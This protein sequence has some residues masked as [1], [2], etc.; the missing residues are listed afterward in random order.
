MTVEPISPPAHLQ[1]VNPGPI[2]C[3][4]IKAITYNETLSPLY[5]LLCYNNSCSLLESVMKS[6]LSII[7]EDIIIYTIIITGVVYLLSN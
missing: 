1:E 4:L 7:I 5:P 3:L 6:R 2:S